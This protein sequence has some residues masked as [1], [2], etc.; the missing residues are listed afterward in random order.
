M[1]RAGAADKGE[2]LF[3]GLTCAMNANSGVALRD[4]GSESEGLQTA[5]RK[6]HVAKYLCIGRFQCVEETWPMHSQTIS[7]V[8]ASW[9]ASLFRS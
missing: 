4:P 8:C 2:L 9:A 5:F 3:E 6:V 1:L 7:W